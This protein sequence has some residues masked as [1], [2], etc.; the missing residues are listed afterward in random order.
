M[1]DAN[2]NTFGKQMYFSSLQNVRLNHLKFQYG[3]NKSKMSAVRIV[4]L[5]AQAL[6]T[7]TVVIGLH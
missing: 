3:D 2:S 7:Y 4:E 5:H 6:K 1:L